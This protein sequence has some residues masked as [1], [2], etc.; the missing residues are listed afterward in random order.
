M[1]S[2]TLDVLTESSGPEQCSYGFSSAKTAGVKEKLGTEESLRLLSRLTSL[3]RALLM[4]RSAVIIDNSGVATFAVLSRVPRL[5]TVRS[6]L[7]PT[8]DV[9]STAGRLQQGITRDGENNKSALAKPK[10]VE[11]A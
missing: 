3:R 1:V 9:H 4:T 2:Y 6:S 11:P 10:S 7:V 8:A 5:L